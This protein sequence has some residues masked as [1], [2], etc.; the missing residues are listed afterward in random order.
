MGLFRKRDLT[1]REL[2]A[3]FAKY[4]QAFHKR[5]AANSIRPAGFTGM[6]FAFSG[7]DGQAYYTWEDLSDMP[8]VRQKHIERC[9]KMADAG[10]GEKNLGELCDLGETANMEAVKET[11]PDKR[12]KAHSKVAQIFGE[13]RRRPKEIIPEEVWYDLA[14]VFAIRAD[15]DPR[16]FDPVTHGQKIAMLK[17]AGQQGYEFFTKLS[18]FRRVLGSSLTSESAFIE[19]LSGWA[20]TR[21]RM[22]AVRQAHAN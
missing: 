2:D 12:S 11:K 9:L 17:E 14:A 10:I 8:P 16:A 15:E 20:A 13:I 1:D 7:T 21:A 3:L 22:S 5:L 4:A 6:K 19:L 18:A